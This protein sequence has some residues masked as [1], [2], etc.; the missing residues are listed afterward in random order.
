MAMIR[1]EILWYIMASAP[2]PVVNIDINN[3]ETGI[4]DVSASIIWWNTWYQL[5]VLSAKQSKNQLQVSE[6]LP[7]PTVQKCLNVVN[8]D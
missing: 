5:L 7:P 1:R 3:F 4:F 8:N 2:K 6:W